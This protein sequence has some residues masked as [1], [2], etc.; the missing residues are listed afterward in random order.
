MANRNTYAAATPITPAFPLESLS[1]STGTRPQSD[2][3]TL[4]SSE[5]NADQ[6]GSCPP[7]IVLIPSASHSK[8]WRRT[9]RS[10][11]SAA[12]TSVTR[13]AAG[14]TNGRL[15]LIAA[16][17]D[18]GISNAGLLLI[19]LSQAFAAFMN[20]SVKMLNGLDPPVHALEVRTCQPY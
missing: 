17:R 3:I 5:L 11:L 19:A 1:P 20:V 2:P 18:F 9:H 10:R 6:D 12:F 7:N 15:D 14:L 8:P 4:G 16:V 13:A